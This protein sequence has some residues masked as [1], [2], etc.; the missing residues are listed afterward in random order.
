LLIA[1]L[2]CLPAFAE[3]KFPDLTGRV[4]DQ[5]QLLD[6][7]QEQ[8]IE[9]KIIALE[10]K[11]GH[12]FVV[13]TLSDLQGYDIADFG[14]QLGRHWRIGNEKADDG[15]L[16]IIAPTE[17][18]VRVEVGYGL[19][20]VLT[21]A[22]SSAIIQSAILPKFRADDPAGGI[23]D[24]VD[25]IIAQLTLDPATARAR[26]AEAATEPDSGIEN[27]IPLLIFIAI[28]I[29]IFSNSGRRGRRRGFGAGPVVIWSGGQDW[30]RSSGGWSGGGGGG[31]SGG[32]GGG[33]SGG[34][35]SFG[36]GGSSG[37]W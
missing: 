26:A 7:A 33:F 11:T 10:Q 36:G 9:Q 29:I 18:K 37:S 4:V 28:W 1:I 8:A 19:E 27:L 30:T 23:S 15:A 16:L 12:Q 21:D 34:G 14:Y 5:A 3:P 6:A 22:L 35:G 24:G 25:A 20:P 17:R 2:L 31:S 32:G 13:V